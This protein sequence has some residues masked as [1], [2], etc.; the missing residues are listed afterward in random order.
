MNRTHGLIL[1]FCLM[2]V[3]YFFS[4]VLIR[5][6]NLYWSFLK[7]SIV[8]SIFFIVF[9]ALGFYFKA[10]SPEA[11][12]ELVFF[13]LALIVGFILAVYLV[14]V[15]FYRMYLNTQKK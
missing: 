8:P 6:R 13:S 7:G 1:T 4:Q 5:Q 11:N 12:D 10:Y 14:C 2:G 3:L 15:F 9:M